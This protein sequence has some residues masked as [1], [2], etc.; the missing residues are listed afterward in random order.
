MSS[1][2]AASY[3]LIQV[4]TIFHILGS[5]FLPIR[6]FTLA[7]GRGGLFFS[8]GVAVNKVSKSSQLPSSRFTLLRITAVAGLVGAILISSGCA[9]APPGIHVF[10]P[11]IVLSPPVIY[12]PVAPPAIYV[13]PSYH[14]GHHH[15]HHQHRNHY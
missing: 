11:R 14:H 2:N 7:D 5:P 4:R 10:P 3:L 8:T 1:I 12:L 9:I 13:A 6:T 15:R